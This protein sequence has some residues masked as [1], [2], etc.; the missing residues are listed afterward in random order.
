MEGDTDGEVW[1]VSSSG[2]ID[3]VMTGAEMTEVTEVTKGDR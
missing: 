3:V 1:L 2:L